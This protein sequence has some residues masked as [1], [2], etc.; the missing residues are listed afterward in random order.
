MATKQQLLIDT[1]EQPFEMEQYIKFVTEF[2]NTIK[3]NA[4]IQTNEKVWGEY[5]EHIKSY[6]KIGRYID[7]NNKKIDIWAVELCSEGSVERARSLQRNFVSKLLTA[8]N[9]HAGII[10][11]YVK[12]AVTWRLS[13]V[14]LEREFSPKGI[15]IETTP[16]K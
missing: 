9:S 1:L 14:K 12:E 2:F 16:A 15:Q 8:D 10:A 11:F 7:E 13:F 3:T 4:H 6:T 5:R